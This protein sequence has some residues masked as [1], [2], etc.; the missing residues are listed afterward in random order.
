M[1]TLQLIWEGRSYDMWSWTMGK[2][3]QSARTMRRIRN[4][5]Y[6]SHI[7]PRGSQPT[8][9]VITKMARGSEEVYALNREVEFY[10]KYL[11]PL[12]GK[13]VPR[14]LGFFKGRDDGVE[15]GC[16][17]LEYCFQYS[18]ATEYLQEGQE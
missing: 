10:T 11:R 9:V 5:V 3:N 6:L 12:Q 14:F 18:A 1:A 2:V 4:N 13:I 16:M 15:L 8:E 17:I 7:G